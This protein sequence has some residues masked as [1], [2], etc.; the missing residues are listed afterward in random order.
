MSEPLTPEDW[1]EQLA[2]LATFS[3]PGEALAGYVTQAVFEALVDRQGLG[4]TGIACPGC[5][6]DGDD[7]WIEGATCQLCMG[8]GEVTGERLAGIARYLS[9]GSAALN[10][11]WHRAETAEKEV[12][13]LREA[14][15]W[16]RDDVVVNLRCRLD[17]GDMDDLDQI[18]DDIEHELGQ[19]LGAERDA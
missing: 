10:E 2:W 5:D 9:D 18:V 8:T 19:V 13:Q 15:A 4:R 16:V 1:R 12:E 11:R 3:N 6:G 7:L 17:D 14:L